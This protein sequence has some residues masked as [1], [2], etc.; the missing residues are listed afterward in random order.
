[1]LTT[2]AL[3]VFG[4]VVWL[5]HR[6]TK[7]VKGGEGIGVLNLQDPCRFSFWRTLGLSKNVPELNIKQSLGDISI[8]TL[9]PRAMFNLVAC[10]TQGF[11]IVDSI[12]AAV[13]VAV[14]PN[15]TSMVRERTALTSQ[16]AEADNGSRE[17][18]GHVRELSVFESVENGRALS[19]TVPAITAL[20]CR[21]SS[22]NV[23]A[24][25]AWLTLEACH[26][27]VGALASVQFVSNEFFVTCWT[28]DGL[29]SGLVATLLGAIDFTVSTARILAAER[30]EAD[31][32]VVNNV[33]FAH[34]NQL[35]R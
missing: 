29:F 16:R 6:M 19:T 20:E 11:E 3:I 27:A 5:D 21:P 33:C 7:E 12:I 1:M 23:P 30:G 4:A 25:L 2:K 32:A 34:W 8:S 15:Q 17:A 9:P 22:N 31:G 26:R 35:C 28:G 14:M 18:L 13:P 10:T 24:E